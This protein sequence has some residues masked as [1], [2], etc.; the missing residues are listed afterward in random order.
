MRICLFTPCFLPQVG[1][2]EIAVDAIARQIHAAGHHIVVLAPDLGEYPDLPYAVQW[3]KRPIMPRAFPERVG[4]HLSRLHERERFDLFAAKYAHPTGYCCVTLGEK[5]GVPSVVISQGGDLYYSSK[6]RMRPHVWKRTVHTYRHADALVSISPYITQLIREINPEPPMIA[7]I[8]NGVDVAAINEP[9]ER[10]SDFTDERPFACCLGNLGPMKGFD[11]AMQA[12]AKVRG[13]LGDL[14]LVIV[15]DGPLREAWRKLRAELGLEDE[16]L[17]VGHRGGAA[18]RWF[19]QHCEFAVMPSI[20]EGHALVSLEFLAAGK[21]LLV[22]TNASFDGTVDD[23]VNGVRVPAKD[24]GAI[25]EGI[26]RLAGGDLEAMSKASRERA[27]VFDWSN[28]GR[29]Y[30]EFF[31]Q[32]IAGYSSTKEDG[33]P[34]L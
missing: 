22:T 27:D 1:G 20:E 24:I 26:V 17:M 3:Y 9:A 34:H 8:P 14:A 10:P 25:A 18:K 29:R 32:V 12:W 5:L 11:H 6:D 7:D 33:P 19:L 15:G 28:I 23:G 30:V 4:K 31:E 21:P 2:A 16:V 13:R